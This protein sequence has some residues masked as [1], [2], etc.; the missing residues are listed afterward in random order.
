MDNMEASS[1]TQDNK[2]INKIVDEM[3][4]FDDELMTLVFNK[5]IPATELTL[6]IIIGRKIT[7]IDIGTQ[8]EM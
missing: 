6:S 5:N 4:L 8:E 1:K 2:K 7:V 3:D